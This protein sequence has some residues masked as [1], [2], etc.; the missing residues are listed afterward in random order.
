MTD[1]NLLLATAMSL[2]LAVG[3]AQ[4]GPMFPAV[5]HT[6]AIT[7]VQWHHHGWHGWDLAWASSRE[8]P[9][10]VSEGRR[11]GSKVHRRDVLTDCQ[12]PT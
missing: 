11:A 3:P 2:D 12:R 1:S 4:A 5:V 9:V 8:A 10:P 6:G 7:R